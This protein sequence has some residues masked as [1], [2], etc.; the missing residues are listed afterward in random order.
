MN[1]TIEFIGCMFTKRLMQVDIVL[2]QSDDGFGKRKHEVV[3]LFKV[4]TNVQ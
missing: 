1:C 3:V 2:K 4:K